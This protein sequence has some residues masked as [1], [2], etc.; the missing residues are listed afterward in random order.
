MNTFEVIIPRH[1]SVL[2]KPGAHYQW[3]ALAKAKKQ[4]T[5]DAFIMCRS[6]PHTEGTP[7]KQCHMNVTFICGQKRR[8]DPDNWLARMKGMTD[9]AVRARIIEDD[10]SEVLRSVTIEFIIDPKRA[11]ATV[12]RFTEVA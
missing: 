4:D 10:N 1:P 6:V 11:P 12:L 3:R 8:R 7:F 9:G 2:L 5:E